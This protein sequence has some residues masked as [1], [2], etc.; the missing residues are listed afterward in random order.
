MPTESNIEQIIQEAMSRGEFDNLK[1]KGKPLDLDA[2]FSTPEEVRMAYSLLSSNEFV[3]EEVDLMNELAD[4]K[5][6]LASCDDAS[7]QAILDEI[8]KKR[9]RLDLLLDARRTRRR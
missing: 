2:Y 4:L 3:P 5:G 6:R 1:G 7:R 8:N 9:L